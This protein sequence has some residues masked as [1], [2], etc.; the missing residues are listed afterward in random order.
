MVSVTNVAT[1]G[2]FSLLALSEGTAD[3]MDWAARKYC[4]KTPSDPS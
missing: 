3:M 4:H 2:L 1:L